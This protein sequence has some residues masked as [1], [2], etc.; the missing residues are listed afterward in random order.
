MNYQSSGSIVIVD[1]MFCM[2][3]ILIILI[4]VVPKQP[5]KVGYLPQAD[6]TIECSGSGY[7]DIKL[8]VMEPEAPRVSFE[9]PRI[10]NQRV[11]MLRSYLE[12]KL[13]NHTS[14]IANV[15]LVARGQAFLQCQSLFT[16]AFTRPETCD[17]LEVTAEDR[18]SAIPSFKI[19]YKQG[20][21]DGG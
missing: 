13:Y 7:R 21:A 11:Q 19:I 15:L 4:T 20:Q 9:T 18:S 12:G 5:K 6:L 10:N 8:Y 14:T 3:A 1:A 17:S 2:V 16:C